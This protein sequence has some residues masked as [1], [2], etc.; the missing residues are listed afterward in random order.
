MK[1]FRQGRLPDFL[2]IG[3]MKCG[4]T[5][6]HHYLNQHPELILPDKKESNFFYKQHLYE[7]GTDWYRSL[8]RGS[9]RISGEISP[10]YAKSHFVPEMAERIHALLPNVKLIFVV[11]NPID[12]MISHHAHNCGKGV[13]HRTLESMINELPESN[14]LQTTRY[15]FQLS[16]YLKYFDRD[17]ILL[18]CS[19][20]LRKE[21]HR[22]ME[23]IHKFLGVQDCCPDCQYQPSGS[24]RAHNYFVRPIFRSHNIHRVSRFILRYV[25]SLYFTNQKVPRPAPSREFRRSVLELLAD[26]RAQLEDWAERKFSHWDQLTD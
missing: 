9:G 11:R 23:K 22:I 17:Q 19:E 14:Y 25:P 3:A 2:G 1:L 26:D 4:T 21:P 7:K 15:F 10:N 5:S 6:L 18:I 12:R 24:K 8:F 20:E 13:E 16:F